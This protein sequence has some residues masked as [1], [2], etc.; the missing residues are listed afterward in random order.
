M[1]LCRPNRLLLPRRVGGRSRFC[2]VSQGSDFGH[3]T[4][5][6]RLGSWPRGSCRLCRCRSFP[7][8]GFPWLAS[9][10]DSVW[11]VVL[12]SAP[13]H[14]LPGSPPCHMSISRK[15]K[16]QEV[17]ITLQPACFA[18]RSWDKQYL[19]HPVLPATT[20]GL[21]ECQWL[22]VTVAVTLGI[23]GDSHPPLGS[24]SS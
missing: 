21:S 22:S 13:C 1:Q 15:E 6:L 10:G 24:G 12:L 7:A 17:G 16:P 5:L 23:C 3:C 18:R 4:D 19:K 2:R 9:A 8:R 14:P 11:D 20:T